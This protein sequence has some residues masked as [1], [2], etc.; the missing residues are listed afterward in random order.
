ML[1]YLKSI[2]FKKHFDLTSHT[3]LSDKEIKNL[4]AEQK[5]KDELALAQQKLNEIKKQKELKLRNLKLQEAIKKRQAMPNE[6]TIDK[7]NAH[8]NKLNKLA[9]KTALAK[10][11]HSNVGLYDISS[12]KDY[13]LIMERVNKK[14]IQN[15][16]QLSNKLHK[17]DEK[18]DKMEKELG[19]YE[20]SNK[21]ILDKIKKIKN[22]KNKLRRPHIV[23]FDEKSHINWTDNNWNITDWTS[24]IGS[25][26]KV[27]LLPNDEIYPYAGLGSLEGLGSLGMSGGGG[28]DGSG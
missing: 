6:N 26:D 24:H 7:E 10:D 16:K 13:N 15:E 25:F 3:T 27:K 11:K 20:Q 2:N 19:N 21:Q 17:L 18:I 28:E 9:Y 4:N 12:H 5:R 14:H 8:R 1:D 22:K 23:K